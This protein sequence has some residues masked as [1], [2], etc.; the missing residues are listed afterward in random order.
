MINTATLTKEKW[1][2]FPDSKKDDLLRWKAILSEEILD[3]CAHS[4]NSRI[5]Y[6]L[7]ANYKLSEKAFQEL[8]NDAD[9]QIIRAMVKN[10]HLS[11]DMISIILKKTK[12]MGIL[13]H[14][15]EHPNATSEM[16][17]K[18]VKNPLARLDALYSNHA[19][20]ELLAAYLDSD[21]PGVARAIASNVNA[22]P[23]ILEFLSTH[24]DYRVRFS[25]AKNKNTPSFINER[26]IN[27]EHE[28]VVRH[29]IVNGNLNESICKKIYSHSDE[30]T[31]TE[32][33]ARQDLSEDVFERLTQDECIDVR[34]AVAKNPS[35][36]IKCAKIL[37]EDRSPRVK[38]AL[39]KAF[40]LDFDSLFKTMLLDKNKSVS[41]TAYR[42]LSIMGDDFWLE[43]LNNAISLS[44]P[45]YG[46]D[47]PIGDILS[48][49]GRHNFIEYLTALELRKKLSN[50]TAMADL[51]S[52][53]ARC[54]I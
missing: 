36:T 39:L 47:F 33:A 12:E 19:T 35:L 43:R 49:Q 45:L 18:I 21:E 22:T 26:L 11:T 1:D 20:P 4:E 7:A 6:F 29:V 16:I 46:S 8:I 23:Q 48:N 9:H 41:E 13:T 54:S 31:R 2:K 40:D 34:I 38:L 27:D 14:I 53:S 28:N 50:H 24:K 3:S 10:H 51:K 52:S 44:K 17:E 42:K 5:R 32:F 37:I 30:M 25:V 15:C